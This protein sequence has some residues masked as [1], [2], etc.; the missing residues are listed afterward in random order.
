MSNIQYIK[1]RQKEEIF[2]ADRMSVFN[3]FTIKEFAESHDVFSYFE[4]QEHK[5]LIV[6]PYV[7]IDGCKYGFKL[8]A[9]KIWVDIN[10]LKSDDDILANLMVNNLIN[11]GDITGF[12][13]ILVMNNGNTLSY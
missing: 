8:S 11:I 12:I 4:K 10:N 6:I 5:Q 2:N 1:V 3:L 7:E 9:Q 13:D